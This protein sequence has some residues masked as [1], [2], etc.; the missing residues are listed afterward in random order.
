MAKNDTT[1]V[2][3]ILLTPKGHK[4]LVEE[5]RELKTNGRRNVAQRLKEAIA[6]GD[7][8][9]NAEYDEAKNQQAFL[10]ARISELE[11]QL[12]NVKIIEENKSG[13]I[14]IGSVVKLRR[15]E[16]EDIHE[17]TIVG[18]TE[19]DAISHKISNESPVGEAILGKKKGDQVK[20]EA[21]GGVFHYKILSVK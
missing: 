4:K 9:E 7:L 3:K 11:E 21:P 12:K 16:E 20:V 19:A 15:I 14:Q 1:E 10:E 6:F 18:Y 8:S 2:K 13:E 5:L 17:Y